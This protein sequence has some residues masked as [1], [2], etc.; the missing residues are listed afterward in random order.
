VTWGTTMGPLPWGDA[1]ENRGFH[2]GHGGADPYNQ[3]PGRARVGSQ[4]QGAGAGCRA[5]RGLGAAPDAVRARAARGVNAQ[6]S[7]WKQF[8][9][10]IEHIDNRAETRRLQR[11]AEKR[12]EEQENIAGG[13]HYRCAHGIAGAWTRAARGQAQW[14]GCTR[15]RAGRAGACRRC[16]RA[17]QRTT[18]TYPS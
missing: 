17:T 3:V 7:D 5:R 2:K 11:E 13:R 16:L 6:D 1:R 4:A 10:K 18:C 14:A 9:S 8:V 12:R 15:E